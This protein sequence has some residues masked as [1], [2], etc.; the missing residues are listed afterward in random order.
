MAFSMGKEMVCPLCRYLH[1]HQPFMC[2]ESDAKPL[3][4]PSTSSTTTSTT[5]FPGT[6]TTSPRGMNGRN[7]HNSI[8]LQQH[9]SNLVQHQ[10]HHQR[11]RRDNSTSSQENTT[12]PST[13]PTTSLRG[14]SVLSSIPFFGSSSTSSAFHGRPVSSQLY[15]Y[16]RRNS[17][18]PRDAYPSTSPFSI[19]HGHYIN[20]TTWF[21]LYGVPFSV[22]ILFLAFLLGRAE[23]LWARVSCLVG[24]VICYMVCWAIAVACLLSQEEAM[25]ALLSPS[26]V[27]H[28]TYPQQQIQG[29]PI[30]YEVEPEIMT[31]RQ[32][33]T[34][35]A[36]LSSYEDD[37]SVAEESWHSPTFLA[38]YYPTPSMTTSPPPQE[39]GVSPAAT[40]VQ[41]ATSSLSSAAGAATHLLSFSQR[42]TASQYAQDL[43]NRVMDLA[44]VLD[45]YSESFGEW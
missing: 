20:M 7:R 14:S 23:T 42:W 25:T 30:E 32:G 28:V 33:A 27:Q 18:S 11:H 44:E 36:A 13:P 5:A 43:Q 34:H 9:L 40:L 2:L 4:T 3:R 1:K 10:R 37:V 22:A 31:M 8:H 21:M 35:P 19:P 12:P 41:L 6:A 16:N 38:P 39:R 45:D 29:F 26:S 24:S 17:N 15:S